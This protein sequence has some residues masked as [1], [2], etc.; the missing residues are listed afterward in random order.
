[1]TGERRRFGNQCRHCASLGF[2]RE[3]TRRA[4]WPVGCGVPGSHLQTTEGT[5]ETSHASCRGCHHSGLITTLRFLAWWASPRGVETSDRLGIRVLDLA[6]LVR[7]LVPCL[8]FIELS[9]MPALCRAGGTA[10]AVTRGGRRPGWITRRPPGTRTAEGQV[11]ASPRR[12]C[13][14]L[15]GSGGRRRS[16]DTVMVGKHPSPLALSIPNRGLRSGLEPVRRSCIAGE[17]VTH[18]AA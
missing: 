3:S 11:P 18:P 14:M 15:C 17:S 1:M 16:R 7:V 10:A 13:P 5:S 9:P 8:R 2:G 4:P 12:P 6:W